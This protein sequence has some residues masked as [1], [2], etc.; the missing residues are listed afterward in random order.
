LIV[1]FGWCEY[2][3]RTKTGY[4]SLSCQ[5]SIGP[6]EDRS[7][8]TFEGGIDAQFCCGTT[9]DGEGSQKGGDFSDGAAELLAVPFR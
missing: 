7:T 1:F 9:G 8:F 2:G 5:N 4:G 3:L 6:S